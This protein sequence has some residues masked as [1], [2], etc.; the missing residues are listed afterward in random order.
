MELTDEIREVIKRHGLEEDMEH[1]II[2]LPDQNGHKRRCFLL[3]RKFMRI[4]Y[5]DGLY[6]DY[7]L[8]EAIEATIKYP[9][10]SLREALY[11][12]HK[13]LDAEISKIFDDEKEMR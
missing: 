8:E 10:L 5:P 6:V 9:E 13:E 7:P 12:L 3:K 2:P 11:L 1:I 4:E